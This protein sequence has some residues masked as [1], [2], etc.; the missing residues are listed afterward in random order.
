MVPDGRGLVLD[1]E[2]AGFGEFEGTGAGEADA[3]AFG[4]GHVDDAGAVGAAVADEV[5][6]VDEGDVEEAAEEE[7]AYDVLGRSGGRRSAGEGRW[8]G[9]MG[10]WQAIGNEIQVEVTYMQQEALGYRVASGPGSLHEDM[11]AVCSL[12]AHGTA[13][14]EGRR[15]GSVGALVDLFE[16]DE[17]YEA[18]ICV[19]WV[20]R[21][22]DR[23][24]RVY[25][26]G[27][28]KGTSTRLTRPLG[29][30]TFFDLV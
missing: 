1:V 4:L 5:D 25:R 29:S 30:R 9:S 7:V 22:H 11:P 26:G 10:K 27:A 2:E 28:V 24:A 17:F 12:G 6:F 21:R 8:M 13:R 20:L 23:C 16:L 19:A 14:G 18:Q 15:G 3:F